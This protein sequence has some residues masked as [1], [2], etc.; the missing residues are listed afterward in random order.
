MSYRIKGNNVHFPSGKTVKFDYPVREAVQIDDIT[1][2]CLEVPMN[3]KLNENVY[4][5]DN[6]GNLLWQVKP[7]RHAYENS[8][9][10][11]VKALGN[12]V[13]VFN[14]DGMV[15]DLNPKTGD[16]LSSFWGK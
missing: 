15:Y 16:V 14:W 7:A 4:A 9:Y 1:V 2:I 13:R 10:V 12:V 11:G 6:E 3:R 5:L 8:S